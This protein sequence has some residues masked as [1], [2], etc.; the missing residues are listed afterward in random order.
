MWSPQRHWARVDR[1][2]RCGFIMGC[3]GIDDIEGS[4]WIRS[5]GRSGRRQGQNK[6]QS[7]RST[8][9]WAIRGQAKTVP[10]ML[11]IRI[12]SIRSKDSPMPVRLSAEREVA[13]QARNA[14]KSDIHSASVSCI[15]SA[16]ISVN[17]ISDRRR[18]IDYEP[19]SIRAALQIHCVGLERRS[20]SGGITRVPGVG[21]GAVAPGPA[22]PRKKFAVYPPKLS[23]VT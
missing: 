22:I 7:V 11:S 6:G 12:T 15:E 1:P 2:R 18:A 4:G 23:E 17:W 16:T 13:P 9:E 19:Q 8:Q 21:G 3:A 10:E 14:S 5:P 20:A